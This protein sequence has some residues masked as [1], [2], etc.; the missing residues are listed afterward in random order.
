MKKLSTLLIVAV[1]AFSAV[2]LPGCSKPT[3]PTA[4]SSKPT[5]STA[6]TIS[7]EKLEGCMKGI[8]LNVA[9][10]GTFAPFTYYD[11]NGKD[12]IG[13]DLDVIS[14]LS[15]LLG[16]E[17]K[18]NTIGAMNAATITASLAE[19]K[20]DVGLAALCATE[21]RKQVMNFTNTYYDSGLILTVN[22]NSSPAELQSVEDLLSG[23]Y[24]VACET[25]SASHLYLKR[26]GVNE[27]NI[28]PYN[29]GPI[30]FSAL[31]EGKVDAFV[32]D[33]PGVAYYLKINQ[34]SNLEMR[35][36]AFD[37]GNAPYAIA[38]SFDVCEK[39][40]NLVDVFNLALEELTNNGTMAQLEEKWCK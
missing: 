31:E 1:L 38:I 19:G 6:E 18:D 28:K 10:T 26:I 5:E 34:D 8:T 21:E 15:K 22:K 36:E 30:A 20:V 40:P 25:G 12:L 17:L 2:F 7:T 9:T 35:G 27:D 24:T 23:N 11:E 4:E 39:Y 33:E 14:E 29:E 3:E 37:K 13:Y 32:Q 16:F